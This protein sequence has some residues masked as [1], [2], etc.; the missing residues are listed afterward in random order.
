MSESKC[1]MSRKNS[2]RRRRRDPATLIGRDSAK[3]NIALKSGGGGGGGDLPLCIST[4]AK[5][6]AALC[7][8]RRRGGGCS[9]CKSAPSPKG[10][11]QNPKR[12][13]KGKCP[14]FERESRDCEMLFSKPLWRLAPPH[15]SE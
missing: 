2:D 10:L 3:Q 6:N 11:H 7:G 5:S 4:R 8:G 9:L 13:K 14:S 12:K 1:R 15:S